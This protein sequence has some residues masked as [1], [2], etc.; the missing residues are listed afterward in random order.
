MQKVAPAHVL[1]L[2]A[3]GLDQQTCCA[4]YRSR[5]V[6]STSNGEA[7]HEPYTRPPLNLCAQ[8]GAALMAPIWVQITCRREHLPSAGKHVQPLLRQGR[9]HCRLD[10]ARFSLGLFGQP[11]LLSGRTVGGVCRPRLLAFNGSWI[12]GFSAELRHRCLPGLRLGL[13]PLFEIRLLKP[14]HLFR[15][16]ESLSLISLLVPCS[17]P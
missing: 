16:L 4:T 6:R 7:S 3:F 11:H 1:L 2:T 8:C 10:I 14:P 12:C 5:D 9:L 17:P 15:P 13:L